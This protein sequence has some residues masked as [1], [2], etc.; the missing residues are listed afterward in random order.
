M[1]MAR[2]SKSLG[3]RGDQ[4]SRSLTISRSS[5]SS[6]QV[7]AAFYLLK[8]FMARPWTI[9]QLP[10]PSVVHGKPLMMPSGVP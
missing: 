10:L 3:V 7:I 8:S 5:V 2:R 4:P 9:F 1:A 6:F